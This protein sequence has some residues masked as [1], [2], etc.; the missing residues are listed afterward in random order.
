MSRQENRMSRE[1]FF[2]ESQIIFS[3]CS[4]YGVVSVPFNLAWLATGWLCC[5]YDAPRNYLPEEL[6][7]LE[8]MFFPCEWAA[9]RNIS[10]C[11]IKDPTLYS[12]FAPFYWVRSAYGVLCDDAEP[13][14]NNPNPL[15]PPNVRT[16]TDSGTASAASSSGSSMSFGGMI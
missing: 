9:A 5:M 11:D 16:D 13:D 10:T 4:V 1:W 8:R 14:S 3:V 6:P 15:Q 7:L 12:L 2:C